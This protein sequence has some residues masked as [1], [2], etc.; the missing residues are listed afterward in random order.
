M[1]SHLTI[2]INFFLNVKEKR[3]QEGRDKK[4]EERRGRE[5]RER[6]RVRKVE[7]GGKRRGKTET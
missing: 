2:F 1:L 3:G 7:G 5:G 6:E 4:K